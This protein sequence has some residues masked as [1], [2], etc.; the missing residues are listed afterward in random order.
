MV[1]PYWTGPEPVPDWAVVG[2][3]RT[4]SAGAV[5]AFDGND[6]YRPSPWVLGWPEPTD[7]IDRAAYRLATGYGDEQALAARLAGSVVAVLVDAGGAPVRVATPDGAPAVPVFSDDAQLAALDRFAAV[8]LAVADLLPLV[9][10]GHRIY[11]NPAGAVAT[12]VDVERVRS[13]T[14]AG[15]DG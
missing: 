9:P 2:R 13:A 14:G 1:D 3:W 4:D 11:L 10:P 15:G 5:L 12:L 8:S 6:G 7:E